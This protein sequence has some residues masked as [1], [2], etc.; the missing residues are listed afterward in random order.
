MISVKIHSVS[1]IKQKICLCILLVASLFPVSESMAKRSY[2]VLIISGQNNHDW[3]RSHSFL[4]K[5]FDSSDRFKAEV[6]L[7]P[8]EK[9]D[10]NSFSPSFS[11]YDIIVLD[12]CGDDWSEKTQKK[13]EKYMERGGGL[14]IIHA[15]NNSFPN[16]KAYNR[17]TGIG[18]W[19]NRNE[20]SGP[21]VFWEGGGIRKDY[22][23]GIGGSHGPKT[24]YLVVNRNQT[25]P[26]MQGLPQ[27]WLRENDELYDH[28]RGPGEEMEIL[29]TAYS[30]H[31]Q[32]HEPMLLTVKYGK[33]RIFHCIYGHVWSGDPNNRSIESTDFI[34]LILR[35]AEWVASGKV[36]QSVPNDF[37]TST[38]ATYSPTLKAGN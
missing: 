16:W 20:Q 34:T 21:Y 2:N 7:T 23:P 30:V 15:S 22:S 27:Q 26:I 29:A 5:I 25:H 1:R 35:G 32:R 13:F 18:G 8:P 17:M 37:P 10:M 36:T 12:Y 9:G 19:G 6:I 38:R 14:I 11:K 24:D 4:K 33:G 28:L 31:S 3:K